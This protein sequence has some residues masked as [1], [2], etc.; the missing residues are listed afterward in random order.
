MRTHSPSQRPDPQD[1]TWRKLPATRL[2]SKYG[3]ILVRPGSAGCRAHTIGIPSAS[4]P[5]KFR[6][7]WP[8]EFLDGM[9]TWAS[10]VVAPFL[11]R[12]SGCLASWG[13]ITQLR[14]AASRSGTFPAKVQVGHIHDATRP[15]TFVR[16][17]SPC[18]TYERSRYPTRH[19]LRERRPV[20]QRTYGR[21]V[22][23]CCRLPA[24]YTSAVGNNITGAPYCRNIPTPL[25]RPKYVRT[26]ERSYV[27]LRTVRV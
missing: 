10:Q 7:P 2:Y 16:A 20:T 4:T 12:F 26:P 25:P 14:I 27:I 19:I 24:C 5:S 1:Q 22:V 3:D 11:V 9:P 18:V 13:A 6:G 8:G 23:T 17:V 15:G 21:N